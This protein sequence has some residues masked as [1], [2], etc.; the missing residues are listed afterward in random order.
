M[1]KETLKGSAIPDLI[2]KEFNLVNEGKKKNQI[3]SFK[4]ISWI[5]PFP[6]AASLKPKVGTSAPKKEEAPVKKKKG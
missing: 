4:E 3:N 1:T 6:D 2:L 5:D